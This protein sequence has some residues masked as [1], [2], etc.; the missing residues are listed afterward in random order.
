MILRWLKDRP[1]FV[2]L[3][4]NGTL[5]AF[6]WHQEAGFVEPVEDLAFGEVVDPT[7]EF[8]AIMLGDQ[9]RVVPVGE[10]DLLSLPGMTGKS[11]EP[12]QEPLHEPPRPGVAAD[13]VWWDSIR[14]PPVTPSQDSFRDHVNHRLFDYPPESTA[15]GFFVYDRHSRRQITALSTVVTAS[16][17]DVE[18]DIGLC[19][20]AD[21]CVEEKRA[22]LAKGTQWFQ[23]NKPVII[24]PRCGFYVNLEITQTCLQRNAEFIERTRRSGTQE[25]I[26]VAVHLHG[27]SMG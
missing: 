27:L 21:L 16:S 13:F 1:I 22:F 6:E 17:V 9:P 10:T 20:T 24:Q 26:E 18:R 12:P 8:A 19:V 11:Q 2:A 7:G 14:T 15:A 23:L 25:F 4:P 3:M 5:Q